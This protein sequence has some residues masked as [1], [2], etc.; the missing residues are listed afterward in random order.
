MYDIP[1]LYCRGTSARTNLGILLH[2]MSS[3]RS[4]NKSARHQRA[5]AM[6]SAISKQSFIFQLFRVFPAEHS[7]CSKQNILCVRNR[8]LLVFEAEHSLCSK[9]NILCVPSK[10]FLVLQ[11]RHSVCFPQDI[12]CAASKTSPVLRSRKMYT[13]LFDEFGQSSRDLC[14]LQT[15]TPLILGRS[16]EVAKKWHVNSQNCKRPKHREDSSDFDDF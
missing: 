9:Q 2:A 4:Q 5:A 1:A 6:S 13:P 12:S 16:T 10:T 3:R 11:A 8:T 14:E 7:L 15:R